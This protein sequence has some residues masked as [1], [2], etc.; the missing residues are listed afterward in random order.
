MQHLVKPHELSEWY[1]EEW[2]VFDWDD[3]TNWVARG[4]GHWTQDQKVWGSIPTAG[5]V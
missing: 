2:P 3:I 1:I 5:H 4:Q